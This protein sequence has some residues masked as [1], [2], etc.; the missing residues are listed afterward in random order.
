MKKNKR[1]RQICCLDGP[2][3]LTL[4]DGSLTVTLDARSWELHL[5]AKFVFC[6]HGINEDINNGRMAMAIRRLEGASAGKH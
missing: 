2:I 1:G 6:L 3:L 5:L 4:G